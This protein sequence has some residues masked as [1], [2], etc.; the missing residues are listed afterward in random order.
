MLSLFP[1]KREGNAKALFNPS[2]KKD[3]FLL[4]SAWE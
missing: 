3:I 2:L 1:L 4:A